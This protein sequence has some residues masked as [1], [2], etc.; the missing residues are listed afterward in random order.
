MREGVQGGVPGITQECDSDGDG[1]INREECQV[2]DA[3][4]RPS[5]DSTSKEPLTGACLLR[6]Q[7]ATDGLESVARA[8]GAA[9]ALQQADA[10][11]GLP[12]SIIQ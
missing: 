8:E 12:L 1:L 10:H 6:A 7:S 9:N 4:S 5:A 11:G 3:S 2:S